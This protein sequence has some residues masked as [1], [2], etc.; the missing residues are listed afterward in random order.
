MS[1]S[2]GGEKRKDL[3]SKLFKVENGE[4]K[5]RPKSCPMCGQ[6]VYLAQ[7]GDRESCGRCGYTKWLT[8]DKEE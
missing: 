5:E 4:I 2:Q 8:S 3:K 7:H 1:E 6:G